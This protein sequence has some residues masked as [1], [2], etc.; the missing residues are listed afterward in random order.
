M[1]FAVSSESKPIFRPVYAG[2]WIYLQFG[3]EWSEGAKNIILA[4][5][6]RGENFQFW[7]GIQLW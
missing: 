1:Y 4:G 2:F 7:S 6:E 3:E 5:A